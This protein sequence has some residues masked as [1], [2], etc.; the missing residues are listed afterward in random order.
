MQKKSKY[1]LF[2]RL[3]ASA[4]IILH[5]VTFG[6]IRDAFAFS[7]SSASYKLN[8]GT[9]NEGGKNRQKTY[10]KLLLHCDGSDASKSFKDEIGY[11]VT[12]NGDAQIDTAQSK[13]EA[14]APYSM[15]MAII[16][17]YRIAMIGLLVPEILL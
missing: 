1:N 10:T 16:S 8:S 6:P 13:F 14:Q 4:L 9:L 3:C 5:L 11:A 15:G 7:A 2:Y 12:A 17:L